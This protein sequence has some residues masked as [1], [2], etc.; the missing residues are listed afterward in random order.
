M[1][2]QPIPFASTFFLIVL[3]A[4]PFFGLWVRYYQKSFARMLRIFFFVDTTN[5]SFDRSWS[6]IILGTLWKALAFGGFAWVGA[7]VYNA[8]IG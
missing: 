8:L 3:V 6:T 4:H 7:T 2:I 5:A 1:E